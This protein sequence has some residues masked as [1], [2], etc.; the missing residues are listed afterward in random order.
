MKLVMRFASLGHAARNQAAIKVRQPL[1]EAAFSVSGSDEA[2][3]LD[4]Y[5]ELLEDEL[6]VKQVRAMGSTGEA[7]S[8]ILNPLPKQ[9]GQKYK[10]QF[11]AVRAAIIEL[12]AESAARAL[13]S[14]ANRSR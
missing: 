9:L 7:V 1:S 14:K 6:N 3:A 10:G 13:L 8:Y 11:P 2:R 12:D 5:A 4:Q